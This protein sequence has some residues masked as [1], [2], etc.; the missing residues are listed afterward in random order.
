M[1]KHIHKH[2]SHHAQKLNKD[3]FL[4][5][6]AVLAVIATA[7]LVIGRTHP[8]GVS[9]W[10]NLPGSD[11][12]IAQKA[13]DYLNAS[14]LQGQTAT[15]GKVSEES[16]LIKMQVTIGASSYD[17]YVTKDGRLFFPE[18]FNLNGTAPANG[19][20]NN[21][22]AAANS[23][24]ITAKADIQKTS[25][26]SVVAYVVADCPYGLQM[27]RA[28]ADAVAKVPA[29][30]S[31]IAVKYIGSISNGKIISMHGDSEAQENLRQI[32]IREEQ[33]SKYWNYVSCYM[34]KTVGA[35]LATQMPYGDSAGCQA[36]TGIDTAKLNSCVK[37]AGRGLAYAK[38]DFDLG[39][40]YNIQGSPT[41]M[42]N[43]DVISDTDFGGRS[44]NAVKNMVCDTSTSP[45]S[46]CSTQLATVD[47]ATSFSTTY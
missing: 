1:L 30:A 12:A 5:G 44:S 10:F 19:N 37:D 32:C 18:A 21:Q 4:V 11:Q 20:N 42:I 35:D 38:E 9:A 31:S 22:P 14:V 40:K 27:Q 6:L 29:L 28:M 15:L 3:S 43:N 26:P 23:P 33:S 45:A 2:I 8:G 25:N 47:A 13:I 16:G 46:F 24:K 36:S 7:V 17:S 39:A 41:V 34:K